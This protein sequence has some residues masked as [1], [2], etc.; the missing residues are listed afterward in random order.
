MS[1]LLI[2]EDES[3]PTG[4][5]REPRDSLPADL[6]SSISLLRPER[7]DDMVPTELRASF[8]A[9]SIRTFLSLAARFAVA[10]MAFP[11]QVGSEKGAYAYT[12]KPCGCA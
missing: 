4:S 10:D 7:F 12:R 1:C 3:E 11:P 5:D 9:W 2:A 8:R 6:A